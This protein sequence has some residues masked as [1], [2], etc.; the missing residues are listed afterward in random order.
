MD[1]SKKKSFHGKKLQLSGTPRLDRRN[2]S[3]NIDYGVAP[4]DSPVS[5][6][7]FSSPSSDLSTSLRASR[8]LDIMP[9]TYSNQTSFRIGGSIEG[10]VDLLYQS[11]GING[12][13]DFSIPVAAWEA[14]KA[15]SNSDLLP[16]SRLIDQVQLDTAPVEE[17]DQGENT[18]PAGETQ[19][20]ELPKDDKKEK[21]EDT[22]TVH[23]LYEEAIKAIPL[24]PRK[25]EGNGI[26]GIRPPVLSP[27]MPILAPQMPLAP[28]PLM[29]PVAEE[30][31][32]G[33]VWDLISS[34]APKEGGEEE[35]RKFEDSDEEREINAGLE[36][37]NLE[38]RLDE[39]WEGFTGTSSLSTVNDDDA[40][41]STTETMLTVSPNG[42]LKRR[43]KSWVRGQQLGSGSFGTVY[44][45]ISE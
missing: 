10:E 16:R 15:R 8:S 2:A 7:S 31:T 44:E 6:S 32:I 13:E 25:G 41:S 27:P 42:K 40:S 22:T 11:L 45:A 21:D 29:R 20:P 34:F 36:S 1:P 4:T 3:K 17:L 23:D 18:S 26:K 19:L 37:G 9:S 24:S 28:P 33:S 30:T 43:I 14:R 39:T 12:P 5:W 38:L 35:K